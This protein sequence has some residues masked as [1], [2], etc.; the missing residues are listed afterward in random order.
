[1]KTIINRNLNLIAIASC[2]IFAS[3]SSETNEQPKQENDS[4]LRSEQ[5]E[6]EE[7]QDLSPE[8][9]E[10]PPL[11][12]ENN[13]DVTEASKGGVEGSY[14]NGEGGWL[15]ISN[16]RMNDGLEYMFDFQ[17]VVSG[18]DENCSGISYNGNG[19]DNGDFTAFEFGGESNNFKFSNGY[20]SVNFE[21]NLD[22]IG[23]DCARSLNTNFIKQ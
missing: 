16:Y 13:E 19:G 21:P 6:A 20:S 23:M 14:Y 10:A 4:K 5:R 15:R 7:I 18:G 1:M 2:L 17:F 22:E 11:T 3:C 12:E 8:A 9:N